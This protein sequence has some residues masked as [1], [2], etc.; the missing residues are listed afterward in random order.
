MKDFS[1]LMAGVFLCLIAEALLDEL[2]KHF[3]LPTGHDALIQRLQMIFAFAGLA[4]IWLERVLARSAERKT[5]LPEATAEPLQTMSAAQNRH[6]GSLPLLGI[7]SA[8]AKV[9]MVGLLVSL[10]LKA[11]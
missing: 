6:F 9:C 7:C 1:K 3:S 4:S 11:S 2:T 10:F 8:V 5:V